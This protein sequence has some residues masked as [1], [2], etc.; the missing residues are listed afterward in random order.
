LIHL[1]VARVQHEAGGGADGDGEGIGDGVVDGEELQVEGTDPQSLP[2]LDDMSI[3]LDARLAQ[4][5]LDEGER[6]LGTVEWDIRT[7]PQQEG[8]AAD[9]ILDASRDPDEVAR[10]LAEWTQGG[11]PDE[12]RAG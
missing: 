11:G 10:V 1:E 5:G 7:L 2:L 9:V 3:R 8:Q 12:E 4:L 6:E